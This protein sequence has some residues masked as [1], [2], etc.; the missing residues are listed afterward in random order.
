MAEQHLK[1]V[2]MVSCINSKEASNKKAL[3]SSLE[4]R[5]NGRAL[6]DC[7][8]SIRSKK[9]DQPCFKSKQAC[10][11]L[12]NTPFISSMVPS[13]F[14]YQDTVDRFCLSTLHLAPCHAPAICCL[15]FSLP[16]TPYLTS[17]LCFS[18]NK[19]SKCSIN[20]I[21]FLR[22]GLSDYLGLDSM[23]SLQGSQK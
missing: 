8:E 6:S 23:E 21:L 7:Q 14:F 11:P 16:R 19:H 1:E 18:L 2:S 15:S 10:S 13:L 4:H 17:G 9:S 5:S 12:L 22:I 3:K 20:S